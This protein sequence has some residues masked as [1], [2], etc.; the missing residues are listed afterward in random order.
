MLVSKSFW[1]RRNSGKHKGMGG[2]VAWWWVLV[3]R[4]R[5]TTVKFCNRKLLPQAKAHQR[6]RTPPRTSAT[7]SNDSHIINQAASVLAYA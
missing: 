1:V 3:Q 4:G 6:P 2:I 7:L 5:I